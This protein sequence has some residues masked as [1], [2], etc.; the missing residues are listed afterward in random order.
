MFNLKTEEIKEFDGI[1]TLNEINNQPK[2][3]N[4]VLK[5]IDELNEMAEIKANLCKRK[6]IFSGAGSSAFIGNCLKSIFIKQGYRN[7]EAIDSTR[8]VSAEDNY[9][10]N[11]PTLMFSYSRS[12][13]TPEAI[14]AIKVANKKI[15]DIKHIIITCDARSKLADYANNSDN[16]ILVVMPVYANDQ[17]FAMTCSVSSMFL[18]TYYMFN[19][20]E[21]T[22]RI[23]TSF[24]SILADNLDSFWDM[25][26]DITNFDYNRAIFLGSG[27]LE[28]L[29]QEAAIKSM[30]LTDG[31]I[32]ATYFHPMGFR[33]GPKAL[34]NKDTLT[35]HFISNY[36]KTR[37]YDIDLLNEINVQ[38]K[39]N[40]T[41]VIDTKSNHEANYSF[42]LF[43]FKFN[44]MTIYLANLVIAQIL[45]VRKAIKLGYKIDNPCV[46]NEVN[47]VVQ[48]VILHLD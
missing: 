36:E 27:T 16:C 3:W 15:E 31:L 38:R 45:S 6:V 40:R 47:R 39:G 13:N 12:G 46:G 37:K 9:L 44:E 28:Y 34:I 18:A 4:E 30:E 29:A 7:I 48:G 2:A 41:L 19:H 5:I 22:A 14:A 1:N 42:P 23:I 24:S 17:G 21:E 25:T 26:D 43:D 33:H 35:I 32:N 10:I 11:E 20:N 8:I